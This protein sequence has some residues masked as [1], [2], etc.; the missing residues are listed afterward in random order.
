M[1]NSTTSNGQAVGVKKSSVSYDILENLSREDYKRVRKLMISCILGTDMSQHFSELAKF[2]AR[3]ASPDFNPK[4]QDKDVIMNMM[5]HLA[6]IS[7][8]TKPWD[9]CRQW[10]ELLFLEFFA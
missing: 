2:K 6:D 9:V 10:T 3:L 7:N 8:S 5:F 4:V 1:R